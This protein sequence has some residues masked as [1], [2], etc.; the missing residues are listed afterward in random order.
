MAPNRAGGSRGGGLLEEV[1]E[2]EEEEEVGEQEA[3]LPLESI[4]K[5]DAPATHQAQ[6]PNHGSMS[7]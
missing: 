6:H 3:V 5:E 4:A 7:A 2:E 1:E